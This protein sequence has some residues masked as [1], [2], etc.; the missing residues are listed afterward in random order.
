MVTYEIKLFWNNFKNISLFYFTRNHF[1]NWNKIISGAKIISKLFQRT[2]HVRKY[3][4]AA[5]S[6]WNNFEMIS[7]KFPRAEMKLFQSD[8]DEGW[9]N[10]EII[11]VHV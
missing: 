2:E 7:G 8:V 9:N 5:I 3:S 1:W 10:F 6:V 4:C 11:L